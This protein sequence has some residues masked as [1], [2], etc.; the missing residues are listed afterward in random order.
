MSA[1]DPLSGGAAAMDEEALHQFLRQGLLDHLDQALTGQVGAI[2]CEHSSGLDS[3]A[4]LGGLVHGLKV[5]PKRI[6]CWSYEEM[7]EDILLKKFRPFHRL[8][9]SQCHP[10]RSTDAGHETD[11][12][13]L[14][15]QLRIFGAPTQIYNNSKK[16]VAIREYG[17]TILLAD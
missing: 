9:L 1:Y 15:Q 4:V 8:K 17:C 3:N 12:D 13:L 2:G 11:I 14:Q 6:Y 5:D 10:L 7:G 16:E